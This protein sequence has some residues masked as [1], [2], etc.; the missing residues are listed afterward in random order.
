MITWIAPLL[1]RTSV[2]TIDALV[3]VLSVIVG[4]VP[5]LMVS[6]SPSTVATGVPN[7]MLAASAVEAH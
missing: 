5:L 2:M 4:G 1:A 7:G 6:V 3:E